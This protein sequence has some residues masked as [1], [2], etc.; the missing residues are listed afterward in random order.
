MSNKK[1]SLR[2]QILDEILEKSKE[3]DY[4]KKQSSE[5]ALIREFLKMRNSFVRR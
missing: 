2:R 4:R 5:L 3:D 1:K